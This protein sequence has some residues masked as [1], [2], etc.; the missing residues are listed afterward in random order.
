MYKNIK[1]VKRAS[2]V[3]E[4]D[5]DLWTSDI[6]SLNKALAKST[7]NIETKTNNIALIA[8]PNSHA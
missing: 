4:V 8:N 5:Q 2:L 6:C 1:I 3:Q 7:Y